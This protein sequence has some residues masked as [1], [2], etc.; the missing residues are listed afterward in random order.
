MFKEMGA[1]FSMLKNLPKLKAQME[2]FQQKLGGITAE[3]SSGGGMVTAKANG[4]MELV[5]CSL[6]DEALKLNDKEMLEDLIAAAVN[7]AMSKVRLLVAEE[8]QKL[9]GGMGLPPGMSLPGMG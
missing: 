5:G 9:A 8:T 6:S 2:E 3:A 4:R 7:Q 1:M